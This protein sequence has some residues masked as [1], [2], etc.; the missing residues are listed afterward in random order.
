MVG[1]ATLPYRGSQEMG[2]QGRWIFEQAPLERYLLAHLA[3][4]QHVTEAGFG[5]ARWRRWSWWQRTSVIAPVAL[6]LGFLA[7]LQLQ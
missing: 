5:L 6:A 7:W 4:G 2:A 3:P 1:Q